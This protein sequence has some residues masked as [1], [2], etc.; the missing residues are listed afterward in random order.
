M[1]AG[2]VYVSWFPHADAL[3]ADLAAFGDSGPARYVVLPAGEAG[4]PVARQLLA[5]GYGLEEIHLDKTASMI[6]YRI[7]GTRRA[8][9]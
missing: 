4:R 1:F 6:L 5:S 7:D 3:L 2:R 9:E 8:D